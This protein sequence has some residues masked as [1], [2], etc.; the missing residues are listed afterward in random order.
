MTK[1]F[2]KRSPVERFRPLEL[3]DTVRTKHELHSRSGRRDAQPNKTILLHR[4]V[5][6]IR[7]GVIQVVVSVVAHCGCVFEQRLTHIGRVSLAPDCLDVDVFVSD[8]VRDAVF[9]L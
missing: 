5:E 9:Q 7:P 8:V 4:P 6:P 1:I 2:V 3:V